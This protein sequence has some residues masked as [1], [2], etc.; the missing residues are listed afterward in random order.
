MNASRNALIHDFIESLPEGYATRIGSL[1]GRLSGGQKQRISIARALV[2]DPK[3]LLLDEPTSSLDSQ[4]EHFIQQNIAEFAK[5]GRT[6]IIIAHRI[7]TI[8]HAERIIV[9][10]HGTIVEH[11]NHEEL[12]KRYGEYNK[13]YSGKFA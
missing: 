10:K 4:T 2:R 1:G 7:R 12:C 6:T 9:L 11:G 13:L 5:S 8:A 3:I